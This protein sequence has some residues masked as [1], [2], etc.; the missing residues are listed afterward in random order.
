M[1]EA[2]IPGECTPSVILPRAP[3]VALTIVRVLAGGA[4][5]IPSLVP[6]IEGID[7]TYDDVARE[8]DDIGMLDELG[9]DAGARLELE[10]EGARIGHLAGDDDIGRAVEE[11]ELQDE[12]F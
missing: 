11:M 3:G 8:M 10:D 6:D 4:V 5:M 1:T 9:P 12:D 2:A 7:W